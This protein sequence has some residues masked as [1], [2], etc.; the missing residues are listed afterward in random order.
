MIGVDREGFV[1]GLV[2]AALALHEPDQ[3]IYARVAAAL[4][5]LAAL[6]DALDGYLARRWNAVS[7]LG[8]VM[9]PF[10]DK[11]LVVG[12]FV[13]L[14]GPNLSAASGVT[15]LITVLILAREML[16]TSLRGVAE[17]S[18]ADFSAITAGKVKMV[19]QTVAAPAL[20]VLV[21]IDIDPIVPR[22]I[23]YAVAVITIISAVPY[24]IRAVPILRDAPQDR[25]NAP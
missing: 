19:A 12:A 15:P 18:G 14:A 8:R 17:A 13:M 4:F 2:F 5:V 3:H 6:T 11:V 10:A 7:P 25:T 22:V 23:A 20:M 21:T 1:A 24:L 16:I 9:D